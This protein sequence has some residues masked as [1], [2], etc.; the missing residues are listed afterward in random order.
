MSDK[1]MKPDLWTERPVDETLD[2]YADW[3]ESY[4]ADVTERGYV[5]PARIAEALMPLLADDDRPVLDYGCGTGLSG[6]TLATH[7]ITPLH[8]TDISGPMIAKARA[9]GCYDTLWTAKADRLDIAPG[10]YRAIVAAGVISLGAAPPES[11]DQLIDAL[12]PGDL[13]ALSFNDPTLAHGG[14]DARLD[15]HI[16]AGRLRQL[17]REHGAHLTEAGMGA[18]VIVLGRELDAA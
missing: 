11:M 6:M 3:A 1:H 8:G 12:A 15:S 7:G 17:F 13:L 2:V 16:A 10:T 14:Y 5:T 18:D 9:K 4:D